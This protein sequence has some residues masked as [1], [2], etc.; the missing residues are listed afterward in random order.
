[1][2]VIETSLPAKAQAASSARVGPRRARYWIV[3]LLPIVAIL[4]A[5]LWSWATYEAIGAKTDS[6]TRGPVSGELTVQVHPDTWYVYAEQGA[7]IRDV[8]V[9]DQN[10]NVVALTKTSAGGYD[11]GGVPA[12]CVGKFEVPRG[13]VGSVR[14]AATGTDPSGWGTLAVGNFNIDGFRR[15]HRWGIMALLAVNMGSSLA[16][17]FVPIIRRRR[18]PTTASPAD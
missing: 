3:A 15:I 14:I 13:E 11:R 17:A 4:S 6:F 8:S 18:D 5:I 2:T 9:T 1:V 10:G 7:T 16:I 12:R